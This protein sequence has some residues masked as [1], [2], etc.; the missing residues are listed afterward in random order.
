MKCTNC[1]INLGIVDIVDETTIEVCGHCG[2]MHVILLP[3]SPREI[4]ETI[5]MRYLPIHNI[6]EPLL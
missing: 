6:P 4:I 5:I 1:G 3:P 2:Y